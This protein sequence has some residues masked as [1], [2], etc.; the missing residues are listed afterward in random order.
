MSDTSGEAVHVPAKI[1]RS[2]SVENEVV[3]VVLARTFTLRTGSVLQVRGQWPLVIASNFDLLVGGVFDLSAE[4]GAFRGGGS[5]AYNDSNSTCAG[6]RIGFASGGGSN[7]CLGGNASTGSALRT[8]KP[9][10]QWWIGG[11]LGGWISPEFSET[12]MGGGALGLIS[13]TKVRLGANSLLD[14]SGGGGRAAPGRATGG[15]AGGDVLVYT[16]VLQME[17]GAAVAA[18]GG[19]GAAASASLFAHGQEGPVE[20]TSG[21]SGATCIGC[22]VGGA[23][24]TEFDP[25]YSGGVC[26]GDASGVGDA[27]A[28]GGGATGRFLVNTSIV[29]NVLSGAVRAHYERQVLFDRAP[30]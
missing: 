22:G 16:P 23:G 10:S 24:G 30:M 1:M 11:C 12:G 21:A 27:I 3:L 15:G 6:G 17:P 26:G 25:T 14:V 20:G 9:V 28:G 4:Q 18:R 7:R 19:S 8:E 13:R 29:P 5:G 2:G